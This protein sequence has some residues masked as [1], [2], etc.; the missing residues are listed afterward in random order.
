MSATGSIPDFSWSK[1][2]SA[3]AWRS[4]KPMVPG[5]ERRLSS[6]ARRRRLACVASPFRVAISAQKAAHVMVTGAG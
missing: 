6:S 5:T 4:A 1:R 2:W 3:S